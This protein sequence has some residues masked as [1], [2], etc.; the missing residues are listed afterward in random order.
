MCEYNEMN[1][2][3]EKRIQIRHRRVRDE[4]KILM[5]PEILRL[6]QSGLNKWSILYFVRR[7]NAA[8]KIF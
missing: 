7:M 3:E 1:E 6:F 5:Y 8:R 4:T 2:T